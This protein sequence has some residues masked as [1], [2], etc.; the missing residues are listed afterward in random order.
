MTIRAGRRTGKTYNAVQW[1][2][3]MLLTTDAQS[4]LWVDTKQGNIDKYVKRYFFPMLRPLGRLCTYDAQK[5]ILHLPNN[6]Y[7]D[8]GSAERPENLEGFGYD[9]VVLNE[10]GIILK[11]EALWES[12]IQPMT[13]GANVKVRIIGTPKGHNYFE[14]LTKIVDEEWEHFKFTCYDSPFWTPEELEKIKDKIA[15]YRWLQEYL[16]EFVDAYEHSM[17][18]PEDI[19]WYQSVSLKNF[20]NL[21]IHC[22][23]THTNKSSSD[24]FSCV[25]VGENVTDSNYYVIDF[26]LRKID[27]EEQ[28]RV[29]IALYSRYKSKVQKITYD[30]KGHASFGHWA[31]KLARED[32]KLSLPLEPLKYGSDKVTHFTPHVPHF[33][34]GRVY[35]PS[36]H[37]E[38]QEA[39]K[40]LLAFPNKDIHDDFVDGLSGVLDNFLEED[41]YFSIS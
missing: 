25:V 5:K 36:E 7:I 40:Q 12:T 14:K 15:G 8:F 38:V 31:A 23:I 3:E 39:N 10:A 28:A 22:D 35:L 13:K 26:A 21:Y 2:L 27:V 6:K 37:P 19:R 4:A 30:E 24:Y 18:S 1:M 17:I 9:I 32:Y 29:L 33:K 11:D 34:S 16:S 41:F 20:D